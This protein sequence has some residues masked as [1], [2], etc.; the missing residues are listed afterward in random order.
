M[1]L[2]QGF[3][4]NGFRDLKHRQLTLIEWPS[5]A[6][7]LMMANRVCWGHRLLQQLLGSAFLQQARLRQQRAPRLG[8]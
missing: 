7:T 4:Q 3:D 8:S 1:A 6:I 2:G 5:A